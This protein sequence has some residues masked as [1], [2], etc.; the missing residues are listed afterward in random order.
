[1]P[2][3]GILLKLSGPNVSRA[4]GTDLALGGGA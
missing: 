2:G 4:A 3:Q 1:M